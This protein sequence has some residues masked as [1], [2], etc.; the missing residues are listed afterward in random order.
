[1]GRPY[2]SSHPLCGWCLTAKFAHVISKT[3]IVLLGVTAPAL[4]TYQTQIDSNRWKLIA[5]VA[6]ALAGGSATLQSAFRWGE[7]YKNHRLTALKLEKLLIE[8]DY[9]RQ[10]ALNI[11]DPAHVYS[12]IRKIQL[13]TATDLVKII[14]EHANAD[15]DLILGEERRL[16]NASPSNKQ[17]VTTLVNTERS[18]GD[19]LQSGAS[20]LQKLGDGSEIKE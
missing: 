13:D 11:I 7:T 14:S 12:E 1:M 15:V 17:S 5:V 10:D 8:L 2:S 3:V 9:S 16:I 20:G 18:T 6:T 4:V 19:K